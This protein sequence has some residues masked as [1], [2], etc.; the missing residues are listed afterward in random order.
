MNPFPKI[1]LRS[2]VVGMTICALLMVQFFVLAL[3]AVRQKNATYDENFHVLG[4]YA[5]LYL[6]DYRVDFD[7]FTL[8]NYWSAIPHGA[9]GINIDTS[10]PSWSKL[11]SENAGT[12]DDWCVK[13]L[14]RTTGNEADSIIN[15]SRVMMLLLGVALAVLI[16]RFAFEL[17][18]WIAAIFATALF[19]FDPNFVGHS[20]LI[21]NDVATALVIVATS[22]AA[23]RVGRRATWLNLSALLLLC[24]IAANVKVSAILTGPIVMLVLLVRALSSREWIFLNRVL[25]TRPVRALAVIATALCGV[26][27]SYVVIW[28]CY[29]FRFAG[30]SDPQHPLDMSM[31]VLADR[32]R[33]FADTFG[34][35]MPLRL[36]EQTWPSTTTVALCRALERRRILPQ[37]WLCGIV[38][39]SAELRMRFVYLMGVTRR[40]GWWYYLPVASMFKLPTATLLGVVVLPALV[41]WRA[42]RIRRRRWT[43]SR[44]DAAMWAGLCVFG[45]AGIF[46][47]ISMAS[48]VSL[49]V[50][51][52]FPVYAL[53][54]VG[55]G[56]VAWL[57]W[58][59]RSK[60]MQVGLVGLLFA[61]AVESIAAYP[62]YIAF[63]NVASGGTNN[64]INLL[65]DA[66]L[67]WGQDIKLLAR[68]SREHPE[69]RIFLCYQNL[70]DPSYYGINYEPIFSG[71]RLNRQKVPVHGQG[72]LAIDATAL[73]GAF[74][75][76]GFRIRTA[77]LAGKKPIAILGGTIFLY[78]VNSN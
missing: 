64:G 61:V 10:D 20:P 17:G 73:Q 70:A 30:T 68:W 35:P 74:A 4:G 13:T 19:T 34:E 12:R 53:L 33:H 65:S 54:Y 31:L 50:R 47:A 45:V 76:E 58:R 69:E 63:F 60:W 48:R 32:S 67:D 22:Y 27:V 55:L 77:A 41:A 28:A 3:T 21:K 18:G 15:R 7:N 71:Y 23:W 40:Y 44:S 16:A 24:A 25:R 1:G 49:G 29:G 38:Y 62:N 6:N 51:H 57:I 5:S 14:Y 2:N 26:V 75:T 9:G 66:N 78:R 42:A 37:A 43:A 8:W 46:L 52:I 59:R 36:S 11:A 72:V 56:W 39:A